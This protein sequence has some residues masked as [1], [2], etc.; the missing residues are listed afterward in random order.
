MLEAA[1]KD[2]SSAKYDFGSRFGGSVVRLRL[3]LLLLILAEDSIDGGRGTVRRSVAG[4]L[5]SWRIVLLRSSM[6]RLAWRAI[7]GRGGL[8]GPGWE[9]LRGSLAA[10]TD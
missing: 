7:L 5:S 6:L 1:K 9:V 10:S 2:L 3:K 8:G 4:V